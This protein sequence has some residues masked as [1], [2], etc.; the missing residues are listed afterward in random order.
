MMP[1]PASP[2]PALPPGPLP[3][4]PPGA[5]AGLPAV[6]LVHYGAP[7]LTR[8]CLANL[9]ALEP[10]PHRV[11]VVDHGPGPDLAAALAGVHPRCTL[12][13]NPANPGFGAGCNQ[14]ADWAFG[15]GAEAVWFL[16]NDA[17]LERPTLGPLLAL[18]RSHPRVALWGT[19]Q[20]DGDRVLGADQQPPWYSGGRVVVPAEL[21]PGCRQ[22]QA[23]ES[24]SGASILVTRLQWQRLG[25]WPEDLFLYL[26]DAVW[27]LRAHAMGLPVALVE[28]PVIH[29]RSS[30]IGRRSPLS[31]FYG[32][33]NQ[34]RLHAQLWPG[35]RAARFAMALHLLQK[36]LFQGRWHLLGHT[37]RGIRAGLRGQTGRDP[38]Y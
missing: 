10:E 38:R 20:R 11:V 1:L 3:T 8:A 6:V 28:L 33:R 5:E 25:P 24:L 31:I 12:L 34:L 35:A 23:W 22:V 2:S 17:T 19:Q 14:G 7:E 4:L 16:N 36:R 30:T 29:P 13:A 9:A 15:A 32:V 26:E 37:L 18:A 21:P 27:C